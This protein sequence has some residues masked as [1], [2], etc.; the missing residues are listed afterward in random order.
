MYSFQN[1][2]YLTGN[3][4][5]L[6]VKLISFNAKLNNE[7][8]P[9]LNWQ[10]ASEVNN[11]YFSIEC[12]NQPEANSQWL[13]AGTVQGHGTSNVKND[14]QFTDYITTNNKPQTTNIF[15]R[16]KQVDFD[17]KF[18]YSDVKVVNLNTVK[19]EIIISPNPTSN[20]LYIQTSSNEIYSAQLLDITGKL[21][22]QDSFI[23]HLSFNIS[24][25]PQGIYFLKITDANSVLIK[26][27]KVVVMK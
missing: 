13:T 11:N 8:I 22:L 9:Q 7:N 23:Q 26:T 1:G 21:V 19:N 3:N 10:T 20:I 18:S 17:G 4:A 27:Q 16:L 25:Y 15:Y 2:T 5:T 12:S 6:P 24:D 14:Y